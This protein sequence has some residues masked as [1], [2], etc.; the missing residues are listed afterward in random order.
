[1]AYGLEMLRKAGSAF[2]DFDKKYADAV[3]RPGMDRV[4][5]NT[6]AIPFSDFVGGGIDVRDEAGIKVPGLATGGSRID[7]FNQVM[8]DAPYIAANAG[9]RYGLPAAGVTIAG[10]ALYD[11]TAAFG[12]GADYPEQGQLPLQ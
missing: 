9:V 4:T 7:A 8:A 2:M 10:K 12:N 1:M 5:T 6:Q 11:M 3:Y